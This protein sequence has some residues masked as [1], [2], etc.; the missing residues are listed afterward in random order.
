MRYV[1]RCLSRG[2][3]VN[4]LAVRCGQALRALPLWGRSAVQ[5]PGMMRLMLGL[6]ADAAVEARRADPF[7]Q[8]LWAHQSLQ[9]RRRQLLLQLLGIV[10]GPPGT[11]KTSYMQ[12]LLQDIRRIASSPGALSRSRPLVTLHVAQTN[13]AV[14]VLLQRVAGSVATPGECVLIKDEEYAKDSATGAWC[15]T[16]KPKHYDKWVEL[17]A[18]QQ[19]GLHLHVFTTVG[20][21]AVMPKKFCTCVDLFQD[22]FDLI[23]VDEAG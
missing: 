23:H 12:R 2:V 8:E 13:Q 5:N 15:L 22:A 21:L 6:G 20:K 16:M 17:L 4:I 14:R 1:R 10:Q 19:Q 3:Q 18:R 11:G 9:E 7:L